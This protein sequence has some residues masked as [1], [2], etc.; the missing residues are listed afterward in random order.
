MNELEYAHNLQ[1]SRHHRLHNSDREAHVIV[2]EFENIV[3]SEAEFL[4]VVP[5]KLAGCLGIRIAGKRPLLSS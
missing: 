5:T 2:S 3:L 4:E 1:T